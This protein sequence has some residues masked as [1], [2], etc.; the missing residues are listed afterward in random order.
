MR[1]RSLI[2]LV[3]CLVMAPVIIVNSQTLIQTVFVED[4][5]DGD[6]TANPTYDKIKNPVYQ[7]ID[8]QLHMDGLNT[9]GSG[10]Y[11]MQ[12][13][14]NETVTTSGYLEFSFRGSL[15]SSGNPQEGRALSMVLAFP[16]TDTQSFSDVSLYLNNA[17]T[18]GFPTDQYHIALNA[19]TNSYTRTIINTSIA[20]EY[21]RIYELRA[22]RDNGI[23][24]LYVDG[25]L[26]GSVADPIGRNQFTYYAIGN[27]GSVT[28]D[29]I[30]I[31]IAPTQ[32]CMIDAP[33]S[34]DENDPF[35]ATVTCTEQASP[36]FGFEF[37]HSVDASSPVITP[38][39]TDYNAGD[40]FSGKT[41]I[42]TLI[43][44][45]TGG[46]AQSLLAPESPVTI[47]NSATLG[48][49]TYDTDLPG[50]VTL[51]L[52][53][54]IL[55]DQ[56]GIQ[57]PTNAGATTIVEIVDLPLA[58]VDGRIQRETGADTG[59]AITLTIDAVPPTTTTIQD[60]WMY[61][62]YPEIVALDG[63][64]E[65]DAPGHLYCSQTLDLEDEVLNTLPDIVLLAGDVNDD[66]EVNIAD[67]AIIV[68]ARTGDSVPSGSTPDLNEDTEINILDLIHVGRNFGTDQPNKCF[69][70]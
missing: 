58:E 61:Y 6:I 49:V 17:S 41:D 4:F 14:R 51:N 40:I 26:V 55:G 53:T 21:D 11:N 65:A 22:I 9:D 28:I 27:T 34:V 31:K 18:S 12:L 59:A 30:E 66:D 44:D 45:L 64:L 56:N 5:N 54:L 52:D 62:A 32:T 39:T 15:K 37:A 13:G 10:R 25:V 19:T 38:Q 57:I 60:G 35:T 23:W 7:I 24:S 8:G 68:S 36:V 50:I 48:G 67:G 16:S 42:F 3:I 70:D 33:A 29:D 1:T 47:T 2:L 20:P 46:F 63:L 43:N 69:V